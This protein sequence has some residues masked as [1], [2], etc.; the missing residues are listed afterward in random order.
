MN[1]EKES[2]YSH[3]TRLGKIIG[4]AFLAI[5]VLT[6]VLSSFDTVDATERGV[7]T[8]M[9]A[10]TGGVVEPGLYFMVP[11]IDDIHIIDVTT[12]TVSYEGDK[13]LGAASKD[14]QQV[15]IS[16][17]VNYSIDPT[18]VRNIYEKYR[19]EK[20]FETNVI[21]PIVRDKT[22][23]L[24]AQYTAEELLTKRGEF[25]EKVTTSL[26]EEIGG[27]MAFAENVNIVNVDFS[28]SFNKA[29]E[30]K[31]TAE[32]NALA[33]KNKL[34]QVKYEAQQ[35]IETAKGEAESIRI[36]SL[37]L[38]EQPQYLQ[39]KAIER[40][41]GSVPQYIMDGSAV[42]FINLNR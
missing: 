41:N 20:N 32:Q 1:F 28:D 22:K 8:R 18:Q 42:P 14:S 3:A 6:T 33:S 29:I 24:S 39:L 4:Y 38:T 31:V 16:L 11:F 37:A 40:W 27:K 19:D 30:E 2:E 5:I 34:E 10:I 26:R 21:A 7:R 12:K 13:T 23:T 36:Q 9:G 25:N 15:S 35:K 17:V